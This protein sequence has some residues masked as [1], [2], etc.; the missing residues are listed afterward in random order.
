MNVVE[1]VSDLQAQIKHARAA[2]KKVGFVPTMGSLHEG[3]MMLIDKAV[4]DCDFVVSSIFINPLQFNDIDDLGR[5]PRTFDADRELLTKHNCDLLYFPSI[6]EMYPHGQDAQT[7]VS[8]PVVSQGLCGDSRPGHFDGMA[9][10]V[11]KLFHMVAPDASFFGEKDFQQLAVIRKMVG[12]L[13]LPFDV[14]GVATCRETSGLAMSS[15]NHYL[16]PE[17]KATASN[18]FRLLTEISAA[19]TS[20]N[21]NYLTLCKNG[22][23]E[24]ASLGFE[25]DYLEI[26]NADTLAPASSQDK[27]LVILVAA[28]LGKARLIDNL[29]L[30]L[31]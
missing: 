9:T 29:K 3:H 11:I 12:D 27:N 15:R 22:N 24:L 16:S 17:E 5:Y 18:L 8:V 10:V 2:G 25:P 23:T 20:G 13:N 30:T 14:V 6:D 28:I 26:R 1:T 31:A 19:I 21:T 7:T 4:E